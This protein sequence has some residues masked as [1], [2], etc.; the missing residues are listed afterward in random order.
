MSEF[1]L[2]TKVTQEDIDE[3]E[4]GNCERCM[5]AC[6]LNRALSVRLAKPV[7]VS[8]GEFWGE[9]LELEGG[10][11]YRIG[12][13]RMPRIVTRNINEWDNGGRVEPF[14]FSARVELHDRPVYR[15]TIGR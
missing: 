6:A 12:M 2:D 11:V 4:R 14:E 7:Y 13:V 15:P 10:H 1:N 3:G 9:V 8:I 5:V